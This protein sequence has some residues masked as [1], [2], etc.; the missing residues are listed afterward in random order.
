MW[1][2]AWL[3]YLYGLEFG[4]NTGTKIVLY[5]EKVL[6]TK[7]R[8]VDRLSLGAYYGTVLIFLEGSTE[9]IAEG[10]FEGLLIGAWIDP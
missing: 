10:N 7:L 4:T 5:D 6:V 1:I 9:G 3:E 8:S 2:G